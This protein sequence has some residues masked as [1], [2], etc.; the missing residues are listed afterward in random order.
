MSR[1]VLDYI[2]KVERAARYVEDNIVLGKVFWSDNPVA[3]EAG[4]TVVLEFTDDEGKEVFPV[5]LEEIV[6]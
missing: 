3:I 1:P 2:D 5:H 4:G 6:P